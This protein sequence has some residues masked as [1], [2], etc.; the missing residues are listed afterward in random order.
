M[1]LNAATRNNI[2][3]LLQL[4]DAIPA[5]PERRGRPRKHPDC[6]QGDRG[7]DSEPHRKELKKGIRPLL[8][9]KNGKPTPT[10]RLY[11]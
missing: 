4:V 9:R 2:T 1:T 11:C 6:V 10:L 5:L 3:Q 7:Y 8:A